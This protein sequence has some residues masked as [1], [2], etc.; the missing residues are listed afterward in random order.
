MDP[1]SQPFKVLAVDDSVIYRK[2]VE[3][4]LP[5]ERYAVLFAKNGH[6]ALD[7]F[8]KHQ[9]A[10]VITDWEM[11]HMGGLEVCKRIRRDFRDCYCHLILLTSNSEK[12]QIV[13]GL[14]AGADDYLTKPFHSCELLARVEV[15]RRIVEL[16]REIQAKNRL[17]EEMAL[18]DALTGLPNRRAID[19]W[20]PRE[21]SAAA[22][23]DCNHAVI[24]TFGRR[25]TVENAAC[26]MHHGE[27]RGILFHHLFAKGHQSADMIPVVVRKDHFSNIGQI[28]LQIAC[29]LK[30][31]I[32]VRSRIQ[33]HSMTIGFDQC[34][35]SPLA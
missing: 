15:G 18:T 3:Q 24:L 25:S 4:S 8:A 33:Q 26:D 22:R 2:L 21:L 17:L 34:R 14:A 30:H 13:E 35:K 9:P 19:I 23:H 5:E 28:D 7:L 11:P 6:D 10:V 31:G 29:V 1:S 32:R 27:R 20:A 16:H 12:E